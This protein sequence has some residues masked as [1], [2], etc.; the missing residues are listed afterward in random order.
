MS[1]SVVVSGEGADQLRVVAQRLKAAGGGGGLRRD[2]LRGIKTA[3]NPVLDDVRASASA[4]LPKAGGLAERVAG[5]KFTVQV[6]TGAKTAGVR[7]RGQSG[8]NIGRMNRGILRHP[9]FGNRDVWVEQSITPGWFDHP[10]QARAE[11]IR[12]AVVAVI[13]DVARRLES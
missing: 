9:V 3:A 8:W 4:E 1:T 6:R 13:D 10:I 7:I 2:L 11:P 12:L 5:S